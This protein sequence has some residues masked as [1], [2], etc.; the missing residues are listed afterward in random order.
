[1][2][3]GV[4]VGQWVRVDPVK[5]TRRKRGPTESKEGGSMIAAAGAVL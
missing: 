1:M 5:A 4:G 2:D 3:T